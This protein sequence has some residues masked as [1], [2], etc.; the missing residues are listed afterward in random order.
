[1][2]PPAPSL[3]PPLRESATAAAGVLVASAGGELVEL[4]AERALYWPRG[5]TLFVADV[6]LGKGATFRAGGVPL[7]RGATANDLGRL[8]A[9]VERTRAR[10]CACSATSCMPRRVAC[11]RWSR[12]SRSGANGT[13]RSTS[14][15]CAATTTCT[16]ATRRRRG[17]CAPSPSPTPCRH[18]SAATR[19]RSRAPAMRCAATS[20]RACGCR[21]VRTSRSACPASS[22]AGGAPSCPPSAASRDWRSS[23]PA[24]DE[25]VV[26]IAGTTLFRLP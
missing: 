18:S 7:P 17:G 6:H 9:L 16:P 13:P 8:T 11:P 25:A 4:H 1:M 15:W 3:L 14:C 12:R 22:S 20:T 10:R 21:A 23:P 5:R 24:E 2:S 26:A 19:R